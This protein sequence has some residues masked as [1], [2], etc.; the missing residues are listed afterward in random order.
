MAPVCVASPT[1]QC[2]CLGMKCC[3]IWRDPPEFYCNLSQ[4]TC[5][6]MRTGGDCDTNAECYVC[7]PAAPL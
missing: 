7:T 6:Q 3:K 2:G 5:V 1:D 4:F